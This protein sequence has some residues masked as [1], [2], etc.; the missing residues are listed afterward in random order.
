MTGV[1][2]AWYYE[3]NSLEELIKFSE[4]H[5]DIIISSHNASVTPTLEIYDGYRE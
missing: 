5:G 2:D 1:I 3:I 4:K